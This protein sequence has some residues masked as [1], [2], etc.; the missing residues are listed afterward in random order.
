MWQIV[1]QEILLYYSKQ[2]PIKTKAKRKKTLHLFDLREF[3]G[4]TTQI[5]QQRLR[6]TGVH[7]FVFIRNLEEF[8]E[9]MSTWPT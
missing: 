9:V 5:G 7:L 6:N 8:T 2:K 1:I 3:S 4:I